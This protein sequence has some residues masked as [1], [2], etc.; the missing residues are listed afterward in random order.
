MDSLDY[1]KRNIH[2]QKSSKFALYGDYVNLYDSG[3]LIY[4]SPRSELLKIKTSVIICMVVQRFHCFTDNLHVVI[5]VD[6][7]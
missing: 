5:E 4:K 2:L 3:S 7:P 6:S 1:H